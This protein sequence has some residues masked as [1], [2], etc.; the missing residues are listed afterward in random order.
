MEP[1]G[2][3]V[4]NRDLRLLAGLFE[5]RV[6]TSSHVAA[7]YFEGK[8]EAAKKRLQKLKAARL[9]GER[10]RRVNES[11]ILFLTRN[12]VQL[13]AREGAL[14]NYPSRSLASWDKRAA[15]SDLTLRHELEVMDVKTAFHSAV[16]K[17]ERLTIAEFSTWPALYQFTAVRPGMNF[18]VAVKPDGYLR[19]KEKEPN[20]EL[21]EYTFFLEV[22][23]STESQDVLATRAVC[24]H[25]YYKSG[26]FAARQGAHPSEFS[27][28]PFR[29]L[30]VL[31]NAER[32]NNTAER[33][34]VNN[35][36]IFTQ[37]RLTTFEEVMKDPLGPIWIQPID[38]RQATQGTLFDPQRRRFADVYRRQS[39][40]E[41][42]IE[43]KVRKL[44]LLED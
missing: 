20:D 44:R 19:I 10:A 37:A 40:R 41:V 32:R 15:L 33:L 24:Y 6:M 18:A 25:E 14:S 17:E 36:P 39:D 1:T 28:F 27:K 12:A 8:S 11:S 31:K 35:P 22:D 9:I 29:V 26:G 4:Q 5:C 38:Y 23:R 21:S 34:L 43:E 13:L 3:S 2:I 42:L 30:I 16:A 7:L